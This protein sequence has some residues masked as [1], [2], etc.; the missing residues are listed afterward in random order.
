[1]PFIFLLQLISGLTCD[2]NIIIFFKMPFYLLKCTELISLFPSSIYRRP[3]CGRRGRQLGFWCRYAAFGLLNLN[4]KISV[5]VHHKHLY[6]S[7]CFISR[8]LIPQN[9]SW[10]NKTWHQFYVTNWGM[11]GISLSRESKKKGRLNLF[12]LEKCPDKK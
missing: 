4:F 5:M 7:N 1:M 12:Y 10:R 2:M 9:S 11:C 3:E 8:N 6:P